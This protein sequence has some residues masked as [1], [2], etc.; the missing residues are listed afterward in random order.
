M[1]ET[2]ENRLFPIMQ[3]ATAVLIVRCNECDQEL[4]AK[5]SVCIAGRWYFL[6]EKCFEKHFLVRE[7]DD[8][9]FD[10][11]NINNIIQEEIK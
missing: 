11:Q 3:S 9:G 10:M 1:V 2:I 7:S 4:P 5:A 8:T 6:C